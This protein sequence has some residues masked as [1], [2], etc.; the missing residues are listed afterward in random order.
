MSEFLNRSLIMFVS[1]A[2]FYACR[3]LPYVFYAYR[4]FHMIFASHSLLAMQSYTLCPIHKIIMLSIV[5]HYISEKLCILS[6]NIIRKTGSS[7]AMEEL[8]GRGVDVKIIRS[9]VGRS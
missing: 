1:S 7:A 2:S 9:W 6:G 3:R 8:D 5:L 4:S